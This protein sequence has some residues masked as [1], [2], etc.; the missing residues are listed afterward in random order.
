MIEMDTCP[1]CGGKA[2][3]KQGRTQIMETNRDSVRFGFSI[4]CANCNATAPEAYG[5]ISVNL[6]RD[7]ELNVWHDDR[8]SAI[9][10]WNRRAE[11]A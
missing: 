7:G 5:Y 3:I 6:S 4:V 11:H 10:S 2:I 1:F 9:N 8:P